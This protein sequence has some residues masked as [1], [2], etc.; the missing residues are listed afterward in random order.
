MHTVRRLIALLILSPLGV[1]TCCTFVETLR[2][3]APSWM[4]W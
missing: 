2:F 4:L 3:S 1:A